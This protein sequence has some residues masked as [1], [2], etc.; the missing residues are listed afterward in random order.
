P[1][2]RP[3]C[4]AFPATVPPSKSSHDTSRLARIPR[5][6][7]RWPCVPEASA[8]DPSL[9]LP[10]TTSHREPLPGKSRTWSIPPH[11]D[12]DS[13]GCSTANKDEDGNGINPPCRRAPESAGESDPQCDKPN[14]PENTAHSTSCHLSASGGSRTRE[15]NA[16]QASASHKDRSCHRAEE[17]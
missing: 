14:S 5:L 15:G 2:P 12:P 17:C 16:R 9:A 11:K 4:V 1:P 6:P 7:L 13:A 8:K 10:E 3:Q